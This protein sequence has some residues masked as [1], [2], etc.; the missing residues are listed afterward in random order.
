MI[1]SIPSSAES[2]YEYFNTNYTNDNYAY[3]DVGDIGIEP[4]ALP[5]VPILIFVGGIAAGYIVD[6]VLIRYTGNSGGEWV[7][8]ALEFN[9]KNPGCQ[10]IVFLKR[11][12]R[13]ICYSSSRGKF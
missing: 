11:S 9:R 5:V 6:G 1:T 8:K 7:A 4:N 2:N 3:N 12:G 10:K 13:P